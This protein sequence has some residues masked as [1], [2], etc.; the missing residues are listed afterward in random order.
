M[1]KPLFQDIIPPDRKSIKKIPVPE[2]RAT[3]EPARSRED[4]HDAEEHAL[5]D[6]LPEETEVQFKRDPE[7]AARGRKSEAR[8]PQST[9]TRVSRDVHE[10]V[11]QTIDSPFARKAPRRRG[12]RIALL[13]ITVL[14]AGVIA[15]TFWPR[16]SESQISVTPNTEKVAINAQLAASKDD[17]EGLIYQTV[18]ISEDSTASVTANGQEFVEKKATGRIVVYNAYSAEPQLLIAN[19][20]FETTDGDGNGKIFRITEPVTVPGMSASVPGSIEVTVTAD[21]PGADYNLGL[22]DFTIPGFK[23]D[24]RYESF[25]A[26][27]KTPLQGGFSGNQPKV[28]AADEKNARGKLQEQLRAKLIEQGTKNVPTDWV[29]PKNA[30]FISYESLPNELNSDGTVTVREKATFNGLIFEQDIISTAILDKVQP[31]ASADANKN[32]LL[33][34]DTVE[35]APVSPK[36]GAVWESKTLS[37]SLKGEAVKL[38]VIDTEKLQTEIAGKARK[39]LNAVLSSY[40]AIARAEVTMRP[41]WRRSFPT[42]PDKIDISVVKPSL[43]P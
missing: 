12:S 9:R 7:F 17:G 5:H 3:R 20:R 19:T 10:V 25:Y 33:G 39:D 22:K 21:K 15:Y 8:V 36:D 40:P 13:F 35:F 27:S 1:S 18:T 34:L 32:L 28:N 4:L 11:H 31:Q 23:G 38:P 43:S 24:P 14:C 42:E 2:R 16:L 41:F 37:F 6:E 29:M 30:F 26:R